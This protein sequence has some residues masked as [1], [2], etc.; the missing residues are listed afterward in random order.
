MSEEDSMCP[1]FFGM[2]VGIVA[3]VVY[4]LYLHH[5]NAGDASA[6]L[7]GGGFHHVIFGI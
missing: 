2:G 4:A 6:P 5:R 3:L 1:I 7:L